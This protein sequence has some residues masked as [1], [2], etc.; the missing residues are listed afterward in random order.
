MTQS[1]PIRPLPPTLRSNFNMG[2]GGTNIQTIAPSV[3][4]AFG[5]KRKAI[6]LELKLKAIAHYEGSKPVMA[7]TAEL[8]LSQFTVSSILKGKKQSVMQ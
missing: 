8:G 4:P 5:E 6:T 7:I 3:F 1:P 2:F